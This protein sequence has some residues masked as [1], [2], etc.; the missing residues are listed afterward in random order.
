MCVSA[1]GRV[2]VRLGVVIGFGFALMIASPSVAE[3][4]YYEPF[5]TGNSPAAGEYTVGLLDPTTATGDGQNPIVGPTPF[6]AGPWEATDDTALNG[7]VQATGLSYLGIRQVAVRKYRR[8][9]PGSGVFSRRR[10]PLQP[11]AP[12]TSASSPTLAKATMPTASRETTWD[13]APLNFGTMQTDLPWVSLTTRS[14]AGLDRLNKT[15][16]PAACLPIFLRWAQW[17]RCNY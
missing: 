1:A 15:R 8:R 6:L 7:A 9:T 12:S 14:A 11:P 13:I 17:W 4:R 2:L 5:L 16:G 3:L 10:G